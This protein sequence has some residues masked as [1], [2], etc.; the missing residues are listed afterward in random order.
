MLQ[1]AI[2][3]FKSISEMLTVLETAFVNL[4]RTREAG[5]EYSQL[6]MDPLSTF[7]DFK[8][9]FLLLAKEAGIPQSSR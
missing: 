6:M 8:T 1:T 7:I 3:P 4:N 2:N 9:Y 5:L